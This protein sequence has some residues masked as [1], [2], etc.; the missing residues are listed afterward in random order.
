MSIFGSKKVEYIP[1]LKSSHWYSD[2]IWGF[3]FVY[4]SS[5]SVRILGKAIPVIALGVSLAVYFTTRWELEYS[6]LFVLI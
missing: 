5:F 6:L 3:F 4:E 1:V 2:H